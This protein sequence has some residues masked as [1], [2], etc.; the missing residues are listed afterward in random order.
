MAGRCVIA[1]A[2]VDMLAADNALQEQRV[3]LADD[4]HGFSQQ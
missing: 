1:S 3:W 4:L 2:K